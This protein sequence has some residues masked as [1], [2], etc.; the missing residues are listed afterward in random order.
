MSYAA[1]FI[2]PVLDFVA[3]LYFYICKNGTLISLFPISSFFYYFRPKLK[4]LRRLY[5]KLLIKSL[6]FFIDFLIT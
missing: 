1:S 3:F 2:T 6:P 4:N 5:Y